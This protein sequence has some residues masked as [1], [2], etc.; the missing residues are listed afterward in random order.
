MIASTNLLPSKP[1]TLL[2]CLKI[3]IPDE[4]K[5]ADTAKEAPKEPL[6]H[7]KVKSTTA[8]MQLKTGTTTAKPVTKEFKLEPF[9]HDMHA[10]VINTTAILPQGKESDQTAVFR[11][12]D[13]GGQQV[14]YTSHQTFLSGRAIYLVVMDITKPLDAEIEMAHEQTTWKDVGTPRTA[15]GKV[16]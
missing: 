7:T 12:W 15:G 14:Y 13:F 2:V 6:T 4:R 3:S 8:Q 5:L 11:I 16:A 10:D 1:D 9:L